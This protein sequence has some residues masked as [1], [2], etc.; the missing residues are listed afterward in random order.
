M[1]QN[2]TSIDRNQDLAG[3]INNNNGGDGD[4]SRMTKTVKFVSKCKHIYNHI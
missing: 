4:K 3:T 1:S 2:S